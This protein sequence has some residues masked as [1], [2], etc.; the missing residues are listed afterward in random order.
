MGKHLVYVGVGS[1]SLEVRR[2]LPAFPIGKMLK[3]IVDELQRA[4]WRSHHDAICGQIVLVHRV[5]HSWSIITGGP[6]TLLSPMR[7]EAS[8]QRNTLVQ[9]LNGRD[10]LIL[11]SKLGRN[12]SENIIDAINVAL[13]R[14]P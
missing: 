12:K 9:G 2:A 5:E 8:N 14:V 11:R 4:V 6:G 3:G 10:N 7:H 13:T 1:H